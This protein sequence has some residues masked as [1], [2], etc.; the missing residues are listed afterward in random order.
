MRPGPLSDQ[1]LVLRT[2]DSIVWF[3]SNVGHAQ[4]VG[5]R[6]THIWSFVTSRPLGHSRGIWARWRGIPVCKKKETGIELVKCIFNEKRGRYKAM[7]RN[8]PSSC[9]KERLVFTNEAKLD[10][11]NGGR[12]TM[13]LLRRRCESERVSRVWC[14][15]YMEKRGWTNPGTCRSTNQRGGKNGDMFMFP[16][17][18]SAGREWSVS[19]SERDTPK[20]TQELSVT[21]LI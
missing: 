14:V 17:K 12:R 21:H 8:T 15:V 9:K 18:K 1:H 4:L 3:P 6:P 7:A 19:A 16:R 5:P 10:C 2:K 11:P 20:I 13:F